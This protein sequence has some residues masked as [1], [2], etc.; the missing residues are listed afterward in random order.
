MR[1]LTV[2]L[3]T[4][5]PYQLSEYTKQPIFHSIIFAN[6]LDKTIG[7]GNKENFEMMNSITS[8]LVKFTNFKQKKYHCKGK[9]FNKDNL[10]RI[11]QNL[12][13]KPGDVIYFY[14]ST[15][16]QEATRSQF[17]QLIFSDSTT[18]RV[19]VIKSI[20]AS[21]QAHLKLLFI[22]G[23]NNFPFNKRSQ[24]PRSRPNKK[25]SLSAIYKKLLNQKA[26]ITATSSRQNQC[27][28]INSEIGGAF[29]KA[30][31]IVLQSPSEN[32]KANLDKIAKATT[33][34]VSEED[35]IL[36][37]QNPFYTIEK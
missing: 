34:I 12:T 26:M 25:V 9:D 23:C 18:V 14:I 20:L 33:Y 8:R 7:D 5:N 2:L 28:Y 10:L 22:E 15:H 29:S 37:D 17:P 6:T 19:E 1:I 16:G 36:D 27:S 35:R 24:G 30:I 3:F 31:D 32:W 13:T 21:K 11:L 4:I